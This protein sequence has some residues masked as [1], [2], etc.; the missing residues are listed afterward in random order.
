MRFAILTHDHPFWHWDLL[1]EAGEACRTWRLLSSPDSEGPIIAE[2]IPNHRLMYLDYEGPVTGN[3]GTVTRWDGGEMV[4]ITATSTYVHV[5]VQG[6]R[7]PGRLSLHLTDRQ[8][9]WILQR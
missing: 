9:H 5:L 6:T 1:L 3:R 4:W 8:D 7:W 2:A